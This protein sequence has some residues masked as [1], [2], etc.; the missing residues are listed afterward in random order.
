M[1]MQPWSPFQENK[2]TIVFFMILRDYFNSEIV[3]SL[4]F[5]WVDKLFAESDS[6]FTL[7]C[8]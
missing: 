5:Q 1:K 8:D 2:A 3:V 4:S 7:A 6:M